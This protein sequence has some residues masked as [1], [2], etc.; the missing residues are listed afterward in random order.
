MFIFTLAYLQY[1]I[2]SIFT[3]V[4]PYFKDFYPKSLKGLFYPFQRLSVVDAKDLNLFLPAFNRHLH[5][6]LR[7]SLFSTGVQR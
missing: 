5:L 2:T 7:A 3:A 1:Q 6:F 4:F